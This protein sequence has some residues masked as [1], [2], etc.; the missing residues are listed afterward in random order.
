MGILLYQLPL[1]PWHFIVLILSLC[2]GFIVADRQDVI[3]L[4]DHWGPVLK[5]DENASDIL[6]K[7]FFMYYTIQHYDLLSNSM[8]ILLIWSLSIVSL[9][10]LS[11][12]AKTGEKYFK[13][14][15]KL[16]HEIG[17]LVLGNFLCG[18]FGLLPMSLPIGRNYM[19]FRS[20]ATGRLNLVIGFVFA[21]FF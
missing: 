18:L 19:S 4:K 1:I 15:T 6:R 10:E 11:A 20:R 5:F 21:S 12:T 16:K 17:S 9:I 14:R 13:K 3:T 2:I 7:L 8:F